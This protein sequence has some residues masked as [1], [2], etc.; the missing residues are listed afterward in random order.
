MNR[1]RSKRTYVALS[2]TNYNAEGYA[3]Y[4]A[5]HSKQAVEKRA[6]EIFGNDHNDIYSQTLHRNLIVVSRTVA[7]RKWGVDIYDDWSDDYEWVG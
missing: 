6:R 3:A 4:T 5:G 7:R 1:N 2:T